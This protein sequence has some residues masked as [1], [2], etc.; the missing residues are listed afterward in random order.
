MKAITLLLIAILSASCAGRHESL[1]V[2]TYQLRDIDQ[3]QSDEPMVRMEKGHRLHGAV[4]NASRQ[5]RLGQ[6]YTIIWNDS[7]TA[8]SGPVTVIFEYQQGASASKVNQFKQTF[9]AGT[10]SGVV[11]FSIIG[12]NYLKYGKVITWKAKL[13]RNDQVIASKQSYLWR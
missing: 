13:V 1:K 11:E 9:A 8:H 10:K 2:K 6:Y 5:Q 3:K 12:D 4:S 7:N